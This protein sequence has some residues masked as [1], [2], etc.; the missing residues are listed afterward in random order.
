VGPAP[1]FKPNWLALAILKVTPA[2]SSSG[3]ES[4]ITNLVLLT[5]SVCARRFK[6]KNKD[7]MMTIKYFMI[8]HFMAAN[9]NS[10]AAAA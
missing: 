3:S 8:T 7:V 4:P 1:T 5:F 6:V 10:F 9:V 2:C